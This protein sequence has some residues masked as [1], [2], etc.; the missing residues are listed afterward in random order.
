MPISPA[1]NLA[2]LIGRVLLAAIFILSG[3]TKLM[4]YLDGS[5]AGGVA[6]YMEAAGVPGSLLPLVIAAEL[7]GGLLILIGF[8][9]RLI[10]LC[11][12]VFTLAAGVLFHYKPADQMQMT[13]FMKNLAIAGGFLMLFVSGAGSFSADGAMS[14][15]SDM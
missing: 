6:K 7:G 5:A 8:Q 10:A 9:T 13:H 12:A 15:R 14:R 3:Y 2:A 4:G 1:G 11:L